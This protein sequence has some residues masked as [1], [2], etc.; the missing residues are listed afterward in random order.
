MKKE[1]KNDK[2]SSDLQQ[3]FYKEIQYGIH[4]FIHPINEKQTTAMDYKNWKERIVY[5]LKTRFLNNSEAQRT[6]KIHNLVLLLVFP[7]KQKDPNEKYTDSAKRI[8][9]ELE[10]ISKLVE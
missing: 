7:P 8:V 2:E 10:E 3:F 6:I 4:E 1:K 5:E 9:S